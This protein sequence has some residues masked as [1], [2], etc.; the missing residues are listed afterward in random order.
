MANG[1]DRRSTISPPSPSPPP[2][3]RGPEPG[4]GPAPPLAVLSPSPRSLMAPPCR[5]FHLIKNIAKKTRRAIPATPPTTP[6][7]T[8]PWVSGVRPLGAGSD[9]VGIGAAEVAS[10]KPGLPTPGPAAGVAIGTLVVVVHKVVELRDLVELDLDCVARTVTGL[11]VL[12]NK[13]CDVLTVLLLKNDGPRA[14]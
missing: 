6:P 4:P 13:E 3:P 5:F 8:A 1:I 11:V 14:N 2:N 10:T 9:A 12:R 7:A